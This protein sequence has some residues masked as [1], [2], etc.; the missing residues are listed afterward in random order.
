[1]S[2]LMK[3]YLLL[4]VMLLAVLAAQAMSAEAITST[5]NSTP[6][7]SFNCAT[8]ELTLNWGEFNSW[9]S[10]DSDVINTAV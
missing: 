3:N 8:G 10:W 4:L 7:Y 5:V 1:M 6:R 2:L 9:D